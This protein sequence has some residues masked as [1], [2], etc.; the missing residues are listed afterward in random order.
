M[1]SPRQAFVFVTWRCSG[2]TIAAFSLSLSVSL[3]PLFFYLYFFSSRTALRINILWNAWSFIV[4]NFKSWKIQVCCIYTYLALRSSIWI[5]F[6]CILV[7]QVFASN[8]TTMAGKNITICTPCCCC[9]SDK[10]KFIIFTYTDIFLPRVTSLWF[11]VMQVLCHVGRMNVWK[12][13]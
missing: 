12:N 9:L 4:T 6:L 5:T 2:F 3:F 10:D 13:P 1:N 8:T 11:L 7:T